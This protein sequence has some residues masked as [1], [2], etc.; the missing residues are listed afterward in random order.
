MRRFEEEGSVV[1][2]ARSG[3]P[4]LINQAQVREMVNAYEGDGFIPTRTFADRFEISTQ[5]VRRVLHGEG[6]HHRK[7][8]RKPLLTQRHKD[9]RLRFARE[10]LDFDWDLA[11]FSDEKSFRSCQTGRL[12]LWRNN[13]ARY[14][15]R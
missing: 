3:R 9:E 14:K 11:V 4:R 1:D 6:I 5:T 12:H 15:E 7:P 2:R 10:Y 13:N 8:A